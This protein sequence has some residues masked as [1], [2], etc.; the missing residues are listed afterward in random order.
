MD[1]SP[2]KVRSGNAAHK[3]ESEESDSRHAH[4]RECE[5]GRVHK[6]TQ[7]IAPQNPQRHPQNAH[8]NSHQSPQENCRHHLRSFLLRLCGMMCCLCVC[9][10]KLTPKVQ[11]SRLPFDPTIELLNARLQTAA[12]QIIAN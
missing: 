5:N 12:Y 8:Q 3:K 7:Q 2:N 9:F 6:Q 10:H 11:P 4:A 1:F